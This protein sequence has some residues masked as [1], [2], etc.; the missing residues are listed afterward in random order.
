MSNKKLV[1]G[2]AAGAAVLAGAALL[3]AKK[4]SNN[5]YRAHV[6][7]AKEHFKH[8]LDKLQQKARKEYKNAA[9]KTGNAVNVAADRAR[10][11]AGN[12]AKV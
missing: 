2:I 1:I 10:E 9:G 3:L 7:E 11:W 6:E 5:K 12:T 4:R 8:K